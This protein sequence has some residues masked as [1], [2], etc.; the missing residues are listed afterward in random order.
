MLYQ[1]HCQVRGAKLFVYKVGFCGLYILGL[2]FVVFSFV[3]SKLNQADSN[4]PSSQR[5][6][7][8][9][10]KRL[11]LLLILHLVIL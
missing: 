2:R 8:T 4:I 1:A 5:G 9:L 10:S 3:V 7:V 11:F 6:T